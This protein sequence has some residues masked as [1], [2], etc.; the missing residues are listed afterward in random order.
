MEGRNNKELLSKVVGQKGCAC[1]A[2]TI[3]QPL[4]IVG[5][6]LAVGSI[7]LVSRHSGGRAG[8]GSRGQGGHTEQLDGLHHRHPSLLCNLPR[9][10]LGVAVAI[11]WDAVKEGKGEAGVGRGHTVGWVGRAGGAQVPARSSMRMLACPAGGHL[12]GFWAPSMHAS[13]SWAAQA[14]LRAGGRCKQ[15]LGASRLDGT[16]MHAWSPSTSGPT[17]QVLFT[18]SWVIFSVK[19]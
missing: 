5:L 18:P 8:G 16:G 6:E 4:P 1:S 14:A 7:A 10:A 2:L 12:R 13:P 15:G 3:G 19:S 17:K 11:A 9:D